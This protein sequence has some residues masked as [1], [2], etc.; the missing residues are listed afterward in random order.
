MENS[1]RSDAENTFIN[2][3]E[4]LDEAYQ[5]EVIKKMQKKPPDAI[6]ALHDS[7]QR[8]WERIKAN[9]AESDGGLNIS[10]LCVK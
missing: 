9:R 7:Q 5:R 4:G 10:Q 2:F 8:E 1:N 3:F 6:K